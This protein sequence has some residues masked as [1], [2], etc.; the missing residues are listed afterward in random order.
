MPPAW[1]RSSWR[2][3]SPAY[4]RQVTGVAC[5]DRRLPIGILDAYRPLAECGNRCSDG[6]ARVISRRRPAPIPGHGTSHADR[7]ARG[8]GL[9][10]KSHREPGPSAMYRNAT[11]H[12]RQGMASVT[13]TPCLALRPVLSLVARTTR[14]AFSRIGRRYTGRYR[15]SGETVCAKPQPAPRRLAGAGARDR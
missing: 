14:S 12:G 9:Y 10:R 7:S 3:A 4:V 1:W 15:L 11:K 13:H 8:F 6:S 2:D 5:R